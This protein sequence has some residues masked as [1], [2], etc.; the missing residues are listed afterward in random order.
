MSSD[1]RDSSVSTDEKNGFFKKIDREKG[2]RK[3]AEF[4][5]LLEK[6][7][8]KKVLGSLNEN[9]VEG[10][11]EE[12]IAIKNISPA[13][14][15]RTLEE[16]GFIRTKTRDRQETTTGGID[17]A[18]EILKAALG[19]KAEG[20]IKRVQ[21]KIPRDHFAFLGE[22]EDGEIAGVLRDESSAVLS[23]VMAKIPA[24]RAARLY[25]SLDPARQKE[26]AL[27]IARMDRI[28]PE[29]MSATADSLKKKLYRSDSMKMQQFDGKAALMRILRQMETGSGRMIVDQIASEKPDL[30][31]VLSKELFSMSLLEK[32]PEKQRASLLRELTDR[33]IALVIVSESEKI[34]ELVLDSVSTQRKRDIAEEIRILENTGMNESRREKDEFLELL[35]KKISEGDIVVMGEN[36][37]F[38]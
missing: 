11:L 26:I 1:A 10:I 5:L 22:L 6:E 36:D 29:I 38:V 33:S 16:F 12:M 7:D 13:E 31:R 8:A 17:K 9:E 24:A 28:S 37:I 21:M 35:Q 14:A 19:D 27:R 2:F 25:K 4:L 23:L 20:I 18:R 32:I 34:K 15:E 3:A 30:A